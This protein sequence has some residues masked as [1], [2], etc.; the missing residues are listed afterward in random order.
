MRLAAVSKVK[1]DRAR[2]LVVVV[3]DVGVAVN[4]GYNI[5]RHR[6]LRV[7]LVTEKR[8]R[9]VERDRIA[10]YRGVNVGLSYLRRRAGLIVIYADRSG[11][12]ANI[13]RLNVLAL[14][15]DARNGGVDLIEDVV[16]VVDVGSVETVIRTLYAGCHVV[17][18]DLARRLVDE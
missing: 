14:G 3:I 10:H 8:R 5:A 16:I 6:L 9:S 18:Y 1:L 4:Y 11:V 17:L 12:Y 15:E 13:V 2:R 7:Q